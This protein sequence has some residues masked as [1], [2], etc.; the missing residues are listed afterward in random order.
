M[1]HAYRQLF[2]LPGTAAFALAGLLARL[3]LSMT[4]IG[5]ITMLSQQ[6]GAYTLAGVVSACFALSIALFAPRI[7]ALVDRYGQR[8]VLP[9]AAALS[10]CSMFALLACAHW[11]GPDWLLLVLAALVGALPSMSAMVRARW[12]VLL[13]GTPQLQTAYAFE[14][15]LDD[16]CFI[17]GP[18]LSV[19]LSMVLFP[20]AGPVTAALLLIVGVGLFVAQRRTEP[21]VDASQQHQRHRSLAFHPV[22]RTLALFMLA[23]GIIVGTIDVASVAFATA[24]GQ[25]AAASIV[26]SFYA[27]GSCL[28]GLFFGTLRIKAPLSTQIHWV[29]ASVCIT[30]IP[31]IMAGNLTGLTLAV[32]LAGITFGPTITVA[33]SLVEQQVAPNRLTEGMTWLLTGLAMGV[34]LGAAAAGWATDHWGARTSFVV[35]LAAGALM[36]AL[37]LQ[38]SRLARRS[39]DHHAAAAQGCS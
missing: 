23:Q 20:E 6:R 7:S 15:V 1:F 16:L 34:A 22:V 13:R 27:L 33:M 26:L 30:A 8:R 17:V 32:L 38:A 3:P 4:G 11:H 19:G 29:G 28:M 2:T 37:G 39:E 25:P 21:P 12:T 31:L 18:P 24:Q 5:L 35:A 9:W 10:A 14:A 36:W